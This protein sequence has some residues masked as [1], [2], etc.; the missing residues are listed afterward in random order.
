MLS[1]SLC[2][3]ATISSC[4]RMLVVATWQLSLSHSTFSSSTH[5]LIL[6]LRF[7]SS[8]GL[9]WCLYWCVLD[10]G[11]SSSSGEDWLSIPLSEAMV[12]LW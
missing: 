2:K 4:M 11:A 12:M 3:A 10:M 9:M 1:P 5:L 6:A 8:R 7:L